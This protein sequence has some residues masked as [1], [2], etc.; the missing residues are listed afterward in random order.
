MLLKNSFIEE[1]FVMD[2]ST[3]DEFLVRHF[4]N[5]RLFYFDLKTNTFEMKNISTVQQVH[6]A[7]TAMKNFF[8]CDDYKSIMKL[9]LIKVHGHYPKSVD[10]KKFQS[11]CHPYY[12]VK[13]PSF[14]FLV[15]NVD[16]KSEVCFYLYESGKFTTEGKFSPSDLVEAFHVLKHLYFLYEEQLD[17]FSYIIT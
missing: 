3:S 10:L 7:Y 8:N 16:Q 4:G 13:K 17:E 5:D 11:L 1:D 9:Q 12:C 14:L 15:I 2:R 6:F